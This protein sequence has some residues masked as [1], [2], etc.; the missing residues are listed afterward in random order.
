METK[1]NDWEQLKIVIDPTLIEM[2]GSMVDKFCYRQ[3]EFHSTLSKID[4][5]MFALQKVMMS[6]IY[7]NN[8]D[9]ENEKSKGYVFK[10]IRN[11]IQDNYDKYLPIRKP[12]GKQK[13]LNRVLYN[14]EKLNVAH[15]L[16]TVDGADEIIYQ[17]GMKDF[18][19][20]VDLSIDKKL[21]SPE[22]RRIRRK[23]NIEQIRKDM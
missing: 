21:K 11:N 16:F 17:I 2:I 6:E 7:K 19:K 23:L 1:R 22:G 15:E 4:F 5:K 14:L 9:L 12:Y 20:L 18:Q 10:M 13:Q 8:L 3:T